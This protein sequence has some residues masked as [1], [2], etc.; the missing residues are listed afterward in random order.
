M[1]FIDIQALTG[2]THQT[3][4]ISTIVNKVKEYSNKEAGNINLIVSQESSL[5]LPTDIPY[6][7][8]T[9]QSMYMRQIREEEERYERGL[10][11]YGG[12]SSEYQEEIV[13]M[14]GAELSPEDNNQGDDDFDVM[15]S[16]E[17]F[18]EDEIVRPIVTIHQ[19]KENMLV[20]DDSNIDFSVSKLLLSYASQIPNTLPTKLTDP[21]YLS[22]LFFLLFNSVKSFLFNHGTGVG[23]TV[24]GSFI[25]H[26][27]LNISPTSR[28]IILILGVTHSQ[29]EAQLRKDDVLKNH[30]D[31][32]DLVS[33]DRSTFGNN[34]N[35][36]R[37]KISS[38]DR[39]LLIVDEIHVMVSRSVPKFNE[40]QRTMMS[41]LET[42][43]EI[44][45]KKD[46][47]ILLLTGTP[48]TNSIKEF[49]LYLNILRPNI[50]KHSSPGD[51]MGNEIIKRSNEI[52][53]ILKYSVSSINP[54][55]AFA[56]SNTQLSEDYASKKIVFKRVLM[57]SY[58]EELYNIAN[59]IEVKSLAGGFRYLTRNYGNFA[60]KIYNSE[61]MT[62]EE[63]NQKREEAMAEF[64]GIM[65]SNIPKTE[66][67]TLMSQCSEEFKSIV[68]HIASEKSMGYKCA[69]Y[70]NM[71]ENL[72][73]MRVYLE[74]MGI[75]YMEFSGRTLK[76][77]QEELDIYNSKA[78]LYGDVI[79]VLLLSSAGSVG[80]NVYGVRRLYFLS[81]E[82]TNSLAQQIIGRFLRYRYHIDFPPNER[83]LIVYLYFSI[84]KKTQS[85]DE[86]IFDLMKRKFTLLSQA[87]EI[88]L[89]S[90]IERKQSIVDVTQLTELTEKESEL[91]SA[92]NNYLDK[93][94]YSSMAG[95]SFS[96]ESIFK[97]ILYKYEG[98]T[99]VKEGYL[100]DGKLY[101]SNMSFIT[102]RSSTKLRV[103]DGRLVYTILNN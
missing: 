64:I 74:V 103:E 62:V 88:L 7:I 101:T 42:I 72:D 55:I 73:A 32:I 53:N 86:K 46:N 67:E 15:I 63:Y 20:V 87:V 19:A 28:V 10:E 12:Q 83:E 8:H 96:K 58:Q 6:T 44:S 14:A 68:S 16:K 35:L 50:F 100:N 37:N 29:W 11:Y 39:V 54:Q 47:K 97:K 89:E 49:E 51:I 85:T 94:F 77:R 102:D 84:M 48:F 69:I 18:N 52:V 60:Y 93:K 92:V 36:V 31:K 17:E 13:I 30:M 98:Q 33:Y 27:F 41:Y 99:D 78:N 43:L 61:D 5:W 45:R 71:M 40:R 95:K 3:S 25:A 22:C 9:P 57:H 81:Q 79:K 26:S 4:V 38:R 82:W 56:F 24:Q 23:K 76:T 75:T 90:S 21:Q 65:R 2:V 66:K 80:I 1:V 59:E 70:I 34:F 91:L